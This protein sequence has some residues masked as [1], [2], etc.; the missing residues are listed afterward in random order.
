AVPGAAPV[1]LDRLDLPEPLLGPDLLHVEA[2][3]HPVDAAAE[4][5]PA[6]PVPRIEREALVPLEGLVRRIVH[7]L[8]R[9]LARERLQVVPELVRERLPELALPVELVLALR[10]LAERSPVERD[11]GAGRVGP[12]ELGGMILREAL[13][14]RVDVR[15][16]RVRGGLARDHEPVHASLVLLR[17]LLERGPCLALERTEVHVRQ[18]LPPRGARADPPRAS[19]G[20]APAVGAVRPPA[21]ARKCSG[22][23]DARPGGS[24]WRTRGRA[25]R[26]APGAGRPPRASAC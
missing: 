24:S 3:L 14:Q 22:G 12:S 4:V 2:P 26:P 19:A 20:T 25:S 5:V 7:A 21:R 11:D 15:E 6:L 9:V 23:S 18:P 8:E 17:N 10:E 13:A 1:Q 16:R